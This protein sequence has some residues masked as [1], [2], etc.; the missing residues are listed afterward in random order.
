MSLIVLWN[1]IASEFQSADGM[2]KRFEEYLMRDKFRFR[3]M[4]PITILAGTFILQSCLQPKPSYTNHERKLSRDSHS[5]VKYK[6]GDQG[7]VGAS[8]QSVGEIE[9]DQYAL[10]SSMVARNLA[11]ELR[12]FLNTPYKYGGESPQGADCSGLVKKVFE[13]G[14][15]ISLPHKASYQYALGR[16]IAA[17]RLIAGD[18]VFFYEKRNRNI[19]HVGIYLGQRR[20]IHSMSKRGV[21]I[22]NLHEGYWKKY[23][24][25]ARRIFGTVNTKN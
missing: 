15:D 10:S 17:N 13:N 12:P 25:G 16:S 22:S 1:E 24:A 7:V 8:G 20:F 4:F 21:V 9:G 3:M 19:G 11:T 2:G 14:F 5:M 23:Y 18:L 6:D